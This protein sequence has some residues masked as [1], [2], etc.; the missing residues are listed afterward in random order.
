[1]P[2]Y[3]NS[4]YS[5]VNALSVKLL[6]KGLISVGEISETEKEKKCSHKSSALQVNN[7]DTF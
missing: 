5:S 3:Q 1:M 4:N 6:K 7:P 2:G